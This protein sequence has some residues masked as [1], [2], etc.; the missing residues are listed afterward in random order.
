MDFQTRD[1]QR[2]EFWDER[3]EKDFTPWTD[4]H[5]P[6]QLQA[7][8]MRVDPKVC[9]VPG[10]GHGYE[11]AAFF[12]AQWLVTAIDFSASAVARAQAMFPQQAAA[13]VHADFF[14]YQAKPKLTSIYERAFLCALPPQQRAAIVERWFDLLPPGGVLFGFFFLDASLDQVLAD[15]ARVIKGPPFVMSPLDLQELMQDRFECIEDEAVP[16][17]TTVFVGRERWQVWRRLG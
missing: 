12:Q 2:A 13:I 10:C 17:S 4:G 6:Q 5:V 15:A 9:L 1:P 16:D 7:Y 11:L 3:F 14:A 8:L